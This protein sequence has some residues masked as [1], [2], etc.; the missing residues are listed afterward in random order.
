M[1]RILNG[2]G[3]VFWDWGLSNVVYYGQDA[4]APAG[5]LQKILRRTIWSEW[6]SHAFP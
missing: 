2:L 1:S 4:D 5:L 3:M 6:S